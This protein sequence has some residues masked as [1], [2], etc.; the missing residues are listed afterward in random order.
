MGSLELMPASKG[1]T[2]TADRHRGRP[3]VAV[4]GHTTLISAGIAGNPRI[5]WDVI[6]DEEI[7]AATQST[8]KAIGTQ[9]AED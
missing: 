6:E 3:S 2:K 5:Q 7:P 9:G 1:P 8:S 4:C